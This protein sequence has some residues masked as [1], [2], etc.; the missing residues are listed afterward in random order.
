MVEIELLNIGAP[1]QF[2][3]LACTWMRAHGVGTEET[4][5]CPVSGKGGNKWEWQWGDV[6]CE[7]RREMPAYWHPC[8]HP[9]NIHKAQR[10]C[11][12]TAFE[13]FQFDREDAFVEMGA[14]LCRRCLTPVCCC[15]IRT[16]NYKQV[17]TQIHI[18][19]CS[20]VS[21]HLFVC[22]FCKLKHGEASDVRPFSFWGTLI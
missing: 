5:A 14:E 12:L 11:D 1:D 22:C 9:I 16:K 18:D 6:A 10:I 17:H 20:T 3:A 19:F 4:M 13:W 21:Y 8:S 2:H 15:C 7:C